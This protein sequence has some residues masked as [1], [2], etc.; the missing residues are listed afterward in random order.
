M[1]V[2]VDKN[3]AI[4]NNTLEATYNELFK[5]LNVAY[6]WTHT[7]TTSEGG[8]A[9]VLINNGDILT[10]ME[11]NDINKCSGGFFCDS[12]EN[13]CIING[14]A[15][16]LENSNIVQLGTKSD[17]KIIS[18]F[19][20]IDIDGKLWKIDSSTGIETQ[21]GTDTT[22]VSLNDAYN[23]NQISGINNGKAYFMNGTSSPVQFFTDFTHITAMS[24]RTNY[25]PYYFYG[26]FID[27]GYLYY[28]D[29]GSPV[30]IGTE[31]NWVSLSYPTSTSQIG[32]INSN[33]DLYMASGT[34]LYNMNLKNVKKI[35]GCP[36]NS[37]LSILTN[38]G[39]IYFLRNYNYTPIDKSNNKIWSDISPIYSSNSSGSTIYCLGISEGNLYLIS[40]SSWTQIG[41][42]SNYQKVEGYC[43]GNSSSIAIAWTGDATTVSH[44]ILTT[45]T[46]QVNDATY[47]DEDLTKYSTIQSTSNTTVT[48]QY[49]TYE[50]DA[51]KD[52]SFTAIPPATLHETVSTVDFLRIT[53]PN[54]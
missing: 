52:S 9:V 8:T 54:T 26:Y 16:K 38:D 13:R 34:N 4:K 19:F 39:K 20:G 22:W 42:E 36:S 6:G 31:N 17:Y 15:Y 53:N 40:N 5:K 33:G 45:K 30:L 11:C 47:I 21:I 23:A 49:R 25:S 43:N 50:R 7:Q 37:W 3:L 27:N 46:P 35:T 18:N 14:K 44:T 2:N 41:T 51:F 10:T 1:P 28:V 32:I 29:G 24:G 48:D 12:F